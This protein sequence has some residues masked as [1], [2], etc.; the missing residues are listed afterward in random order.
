MLTVKTSK[1]QNEHMFSGLPPAADLRLGARGYEGAC[2]I[3]VS[4]RP[5]L[6]SPNWYSD[7]ALRLTDYEWPARRPMLPNKPHGARP[8][9]PKTALLGVAVRRT[10]ARYAGQLAHAQPA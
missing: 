6:K 9:R 4:Y 10:V 8:V 2:L 7:H 3:E 1:A 5:H